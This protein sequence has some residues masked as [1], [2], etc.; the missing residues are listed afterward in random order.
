MSVGLV[1]SDFRGGLL[2]TTLIHEM[3]AKQAPSVETQLEREQEE[4]HN[5]THSH[6]HT[7]NFMTHVNTYDVTCMQV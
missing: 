4:V 2:D 6:R 5:Q 7:H 3:W 1:K